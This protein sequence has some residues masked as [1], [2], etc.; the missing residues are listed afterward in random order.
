MS[1]VF[2]FDW[3]DT[4]M[5]DFENQSG[6]MKDWPN[7]EEVRGAQVA[8]KKLSKLSNLYVATGSQG[9]S[10]ALMKSAFL[11]TSLNTYL[12]G[13]FCPDNVGYEKP[14][15]EFYREIA[16]K[17]NCNI[18]DITMVG[19]NLDRDILPALAVGMSAIW[20]NPNGQNNLHNVTQIKCL[21]ELNVI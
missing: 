16:K 8:L 20:F 3:G 9:T 7:V 11:R 6:H 1:N 14:S 15:P 4:L 2:L 17:I 10:E 18:K 5:V 21:S 13:Y 12:C 19:D